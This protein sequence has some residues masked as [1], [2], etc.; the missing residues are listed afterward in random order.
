MSRIFS[1]CLRLGL[2]K[3]KKNVTCEV[4]GLLISRTAFNS[5]AVQEGRISALKGVEVD[6]GPALLI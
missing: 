4:E 5:I 1:S 3:K 6:V 2:K